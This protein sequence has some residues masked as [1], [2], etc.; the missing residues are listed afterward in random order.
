MFGISSPTRD[1]NDKNHVS[2]SLT[3]QCLRFSTRK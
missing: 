3:W 2:D 1:L